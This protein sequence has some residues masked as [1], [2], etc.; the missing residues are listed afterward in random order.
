MWLSQF[1]GHPPL[2]DIQPRIDRVAL[3]LEILCKTIRGWESYYSNIWLSQFQGHPPLK[4][5]Q[6]TG[7]RVALNCE[8]IYKTFLTNQNSAHGI[9]D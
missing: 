2:K 9:Y 3:N 4:D 8:T 5:I 1:Q 7:D 6:P